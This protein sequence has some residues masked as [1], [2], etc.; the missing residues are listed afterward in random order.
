MEPIVA[1]SLPLNFGTARH[2]LEVNGCT[3]LQRNEHF[4]CRNITLAAD[5][6]ECDWQVQLENKLHVMWNW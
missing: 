1:R 2:G 4:V 3:Q 6:V 5:T